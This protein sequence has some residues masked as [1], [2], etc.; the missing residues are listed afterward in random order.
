MNR[1][2]TVLKFAWNR[3]KSETIIAIVV[4]L[5]SLL[6]VVFF[7]FFNTCVPATSIYSTFID[8]I[9]SGFT[10]LLAFFLT[11]QRYRTAWEESLSKKL[12][13]HFKYQNTYVLTCYEAYLSGESDIRQW[14]QQI[15][16][17]MTSINFLKFF[18]YIDGEN[19]IVNDEYKL[20]TITFYFKSL[21]SNDDFDAKT[22][23]PERKE[24]VQNNYTIWWEND[25]KTEENKELIIKERPKQ[26]VKKQEAI[27]I[28]AREVANKDSENT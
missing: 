1:I 3:F 13:V 26:P 14:G 25:S 28:K 15:G 12:T 21:P 22:A 20:F 5:I 27:I 10:F 18:P 4:F 2:K 24:Q 16:S 9:V 17:Q 11:Y 8:P 6:V 19:E 23:L 7:K